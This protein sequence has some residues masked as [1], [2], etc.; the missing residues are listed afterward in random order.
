MNI[1]FDDNSCHKSLAPLTLT[2][3]VADVRL[4]IETIRESWM[5]YIGEQH[6]I[7]RVGFITEDYLQVKY[8]PIK[9][10]GLTLMGNVKPT[11][12]VADL[13]NKL[14]EG[15]ALYINDIKIAHFNTE[16]TRVDYK[17]DEDELIVI[18]YP[19]DLFQQNGK[20]IVCDF[21]ALTADRS[22]QQLSSSNQ[23]IGNGNI[24]VEPGAKI[25]CAILNTENGPIYIGKNAEIMEGSII[26]G[27][28]SLGDHAVLKMGAK[29][30][31]DTT[32]GSHC[33]VGGEVTNSIF[34][35]YSNKGHDGFV[36]NSI[37][38]EWCNLGA[39]TNTSNLKNNYSPVRLYSYETQDMEETGVT[40][41]GVMMGDHVKTGINTM[42]N[43][44]TSIGVCS[45]VFGG[46]F[47]S[48][49]IPSF[50]WGAVHSNDLFKLEKAFEVADNMMKRRNTELSQADRKILTYLF[51]ELA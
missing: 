3:P 27:P 48:K 2:R 44:A 36:G 1:I 37:I 42:L 10:L 40:F 50:S 26:R 12:L 49:F 38:G 47:P 4:G 20:A 22:T 35:A 7:D 46:G 9:E 51:Q 18:H 34:F 5:R 11:P 23:L 15:E 28:F 19:W 14:Q 13:V 8:P 16:S 21:D 41:F 25:E 29:I 17:M 32:I 33:K 45:N 39:D 24:F 6:T 43:T 31:G 30:Y